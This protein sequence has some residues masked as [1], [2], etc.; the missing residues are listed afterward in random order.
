MYVHY[1]GRYGIETD[2][3]KDVVRACIIKVIF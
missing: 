1:L 2:Q 3:T